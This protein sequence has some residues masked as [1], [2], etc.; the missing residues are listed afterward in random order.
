MSENA[1]LFS[2]YDLRKKSIFSSFISALPDLLDLNISI[3]NLLLNL[4]LPVLIY[5]PAPH[6]IS[7]SAS[8]EKFIPTYS[9][10]LLPDHLRRSW[11]SALMVILYKH[12]YISSSNH[13]R[14]VRNLIQIVQNTLESALEHKCN[15]DAAS[16]KSRE[17]RELQA[18]HEE[19][20]NRI[21]DSLTGV[22]VL[23][24]SICSKI[25][26]DADIEQ[27][28]CDHLDPKQSTIPMQV[29]EISDDEINAISMLI[30]QAKEHD[31]C[32]I[33]SSSNKIVE[34]RLN[35]D[36]IQDKEREMDVIKS[37]I[38][39]NNDSHQ[40]IRMDK[41]NDGPK[42][43]SKKQKNIKESLPGRSESSEVIRN[44]SD[45]KPHSSNINRLDSSDKT[46][47]PI[48]Q[49]TENTKNTCCCC[50]S[51][52]ANQ[53]CCVEYI[54]TIEL[55]QLSRT[56]SSANYQQ[57]NERLLPI[58][59][60]PHYLRERSNKSF[61]KPSAKTALTLKKSER[62]HES[63]LV[64]QQHNSKTDSGDPGLKANPSLLKS[65]DL[66]LDE[67]RISMIN[68][69]SKPGKHKI[70]HSDGN[71]EHYEDDG[72]K[73]KEIEQFATLRSSSTPNLDTIRSM[74]S[75][76]I[77]AQSKSAFTQ[78]SSPSKEMN[79]SK[80]FETINKKSKDRKM[81][82]NK[83]RSK[84][85]NLNS[86]SLPSRSS[87]LETKNLIDENSN[88]QTMESDRIL[89]IV[90]EIDDVKPDSSN[91]G[92]AEVSNISTFNQSAND[93]GTI[94]HIRQEQQQNLITT[95]KN[96]AGRSN[97]SSVSD[98]LI[99]QSELCINCGL[100]IEKFDE[101][102]LGLCL[103]SL[104]TF[105]HREPT[106]AAPLLPQILKLV[107]RYALRCVFPWQMERFDRMKMLEENKF[108][109]EF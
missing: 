46:Y 16:K 96:D 8:N 37:N 51:S 101:H 60:I 53:D 30:E 25:V 58:G 3:G 31:R 80:T 5:S 98:T 24:N 79:V 39:D 90:S 10:R 44:I 28:N 17:Q 45:K 81:K 77:S 61:E 95:N 57:S 43:K 94:E 18:N 63:G 13:S 29:N 59:P 64:C 35:C 88:E 106:L 68:R 27:S 34:S 26:V 84:K 11:L 100:S 22:D 23:A 15:P 33:Q 86:I 87:I 74:N 38:M 99:Y 32:E 19:I 73:R 7:Y 71:D 91:L 56:T 40:E 69:E 54:R 78:P 67:T 75:K 52:K 20:L 1:F 47:D 93:E 50:C 65:I 2:A 14:F 108:F 36:E 6:Q 102:E 83:R 9:L 62:D 66:N 42:H 70:K 109:V 12:N 104:A 82:K 105:V 92:P 103:V 21:S 85:N 107:S 49:Q 48:K 97:D 72:L 55:F 89:K 4:I 41:H 76:T